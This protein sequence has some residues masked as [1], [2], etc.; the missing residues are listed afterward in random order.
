[1]PR[2]RD[3]GYLLCGPANRYT[4]PSVRWIRHV[5]A[6]DAAPDLCPMGARPGDTPRTNIVAEPDEALSG[7]LVQVE[8]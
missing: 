4:K 2:A 7:K 1:M 3:Q 5:S 6:N 8:L